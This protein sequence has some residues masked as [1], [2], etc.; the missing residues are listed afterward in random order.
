MKWED[1]GEI[2]ELLGALGVIVSLVYLAKQIS[3]TNQN[4]DQNTKALLNQGEAASISGVSEIVL[5]QI[6]DPAIAELMFKGHS[7]FDHLD[8]VDRYR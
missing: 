4:V 6:A 3:N 5:P 2:A 8:S 7:E 1:I